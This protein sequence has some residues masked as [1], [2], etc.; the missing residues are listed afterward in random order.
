MNRPPIRASLLARLSPAVAA[1]RAGRRGRPAPLLR[2]ARMIFFVVA[3]GLASWLGFSAWLARH[4]VARPAEVYAEPAPQLDWVTLDE[5]RLTSA[6]GE[7]VG[8]WFAPASGDP[9]DAPTVLSL[10]GNTGD[11]GSMLPVLKLFHDAGF[12]TAAVAGVAVQ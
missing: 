10:H 9:G 4:Y 8:F 3:L 2:L 7:Q 5:A 11:R 12:P 6:D 1:H